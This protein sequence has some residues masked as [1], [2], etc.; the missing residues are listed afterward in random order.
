MKKIISLIALI[1][2]LIDC[3]VI[4]EENTH[5]YIDWALIR[6]GSEFVSKNV[7][8]DGYIDFEGGGNFPGVYL[9]EDHESLERKRVFRSIRI[10]S[11]SLCK[12]INDRF[13]WD[14]EQWRVL[15]GLYVEIEGELAI[16]KLGYRHCEPGLGILSNV[17]RV[18]VKNRGLD[19]LVLVP[20]KPD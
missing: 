16:E 2:C 11:E 3:Q 14:N 13:G 9:W 8:I 4:C 7:I 18:A 15:A 20:S 6:S 1:A 17:R 12:L 5:H 19:L 10:D